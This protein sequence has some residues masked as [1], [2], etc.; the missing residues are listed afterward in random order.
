MKKLQ[1]LQAGRTNQELDA[2][3]LEQQVHAKDKSDDFSFV[4]CVAFGGAKVVSEHNG[5][6]E[7]WFVEYC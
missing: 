5:L 6:Y 4:Y 2:E 1:K 3:E 7:S